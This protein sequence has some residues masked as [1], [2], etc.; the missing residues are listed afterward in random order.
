MISNIEATQNNFRI[1][2]RIVNKSVIQTVF[3]ASSDHCDFFI[4]LEKNYSDL[5]KS[6]GL[7]FVFLE[8]LKNI[9]QF[10]HLFKLF[11]S[12]FVAILIPKLFK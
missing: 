8:E 12:K 10:L 11:A 5:A 2:L 7:V 3:V 4:R 6:P 1:A 9:I